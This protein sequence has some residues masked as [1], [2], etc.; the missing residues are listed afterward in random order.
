MTQDRGGNVA[1]IKRIACGPQTCEAVA[2]P[3]CPLLIHHVL[4]RATQVAQH[5]YLAD[6]R[7][8]ATGQEDGGRG[9]P[10]GKILLTR[11]E[12]LRE[13]GVCREA[14]AREADRR[15]GDL[16]ERHCAEALQRREPNA[17][18]RRN[19]AVQQSL[20]DPAP[21]IA[22]EELQV[23]RLRP[24]ADATNNVCFVARAQMDHRR[25]DAAEADELTLQHI[26]GKA[27]GYTGVNRIAAGFQDL[28]AGERC[29]VVSR[30]Y[31]MSLGY[32]LRP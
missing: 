5:E 3:V 4:Q 18:C 21:V 32:N 16:T 20:R 15:T 9:L 26:D 31:N 14:V 17:R 28:Q 19:H 24:N 29:V 7:W 2:T 8:A 1:A 6:L 13:E 27:C 23:R 25:R 11:C 12:L 30:Y 22:M 10:P